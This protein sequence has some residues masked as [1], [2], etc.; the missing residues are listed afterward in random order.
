[1]N[2]SLKLALTFFLIL[3]AAAGAE[4]TATTTP[5]LSP[6]MAQAMA[7]MEPLQK[8]GQADLA[9]MDGDQAKSKEL[10]EQAVAELDAILEKSPETV[11]ALNSRGLAK[12]M[13]SEGTGN[14]DLEASIAISTKTIQT[15]PDNARAY[16]DR[17]AAYRKLKRYDEAEA[18]YLQAIKLAPEKAHWQTELRAMKAEAGL[19]STPN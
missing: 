16:Y 18:D 4:D 1:M 6:E 19:Y 14:A 8:M 17:A 3:P 10:L 13:L 7:L 2:Y 11:V 12:N 9:R 15:K 5:K